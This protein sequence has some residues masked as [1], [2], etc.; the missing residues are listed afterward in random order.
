MCLLKSKLIKIMISIFPEIK[1]CFYKTLNWV[2]KTPWKPLNQKL[3]WRPISGVAWKTNAWFDKKKVGYSCGFSQQ[4][5]VCFVEIFLKCS[6]PVVHLLL[7]I[8]DCFGKTAQCDKKWGKWGA[9]CCECCEFTL[10]S[11]RFLCFFP[12]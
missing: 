2:H 5:T 3:R 10:F 8:T 11:A 1:L 7:Q 6:V 12:A 4:T 9:V